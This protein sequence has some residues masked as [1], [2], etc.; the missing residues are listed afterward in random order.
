[1]NDRGKWTES[2][3]IGGGG[4]RPEMTEQSLGTHLLQLLADAV[5]RRRGDYNLSL[6]LLSM[7]C[8]CSGIGQRGQLL[9]F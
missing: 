7:M 5:G 3:E 2:K 8:R 4:G 1:M 9:Q 6:L